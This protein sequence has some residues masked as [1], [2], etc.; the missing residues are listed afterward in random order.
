MTL[1]TYERIH[2]D[3]DVEAR[4]KCQSNAW[5]VLRCAALIFL[6]AVLI[7]LISAIFIVLPTL[8]GV[9]STHTKSTCSVS[10]NYVIHAGVKTLF[11]RYGT[12]ADT[13]ATACYLTDNAIAGKTAFLTINQLV[14]GDVCGIYSIMSIIV[15]GLGLLILLCVAVPYAFRFF[16]GFRICQ[17]ICIFR[18]SHYTAE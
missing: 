1:P 15:W 3:T 8:A 9:C 4:Q 5:S 2:E 12:V 13:N 6:Q 16:S 10:N 14:F 17:R 18:V 11:Y 7:G